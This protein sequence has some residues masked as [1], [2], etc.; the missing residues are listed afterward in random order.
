MSSTVDSV[1]HAD[2]WDEL[3]QTRQRGRGVNVGRTERIVSGALG[4]ALVGLALRRRS[5][6]SFLLPIGGG[7]VWRAIT[8]KCPVNRAMGRNGA[9][10]H[11]GRQTPF[12]SVE[13]GEG[14]KVEE[15]IVVQRPAGELY[16]FWRNFENLPRIMDHLESVAVLDDRRSRWKAKAPAGSSVEWDAEIHNEI[17]DELIAWR[18]LP[19]SDVDNAG[20]V[21][22]RPAPGGVGTEVRV[23]LRYDPPAGRLGA[24]IAKLFGEEPA[25]QVRA[26]LRRFREV[27]EMGD[28]VAGAG[29]NGQFGNGRRE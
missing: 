1:V 23:V 7:L 22:F 11:G 21:H 6:R 25:Q 19:G 5:L 24:T 12:T 20:S 14:M 3:P 8:G 26:D 15:R 4:A 27:M 16:R 17:E 2:S 13:R 18:S 10:P 28:P 29:G 9:L